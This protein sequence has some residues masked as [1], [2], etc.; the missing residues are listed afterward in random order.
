MGDLMP[1]VAGWSTLISAGLAEPNRQPQQAAAAV[2][3]ISLVVLV[4]QDIRASATIAHAMLYQMPCG[5]QTRPSMD[6]ACIAQNPILLARDY[7][8]CHG[9]LTGVPT[10]H[11]FTD[12]QLFCYLTIGVTM[13]IAA[14]GYTLWAL[15]LV[16]AI[17]MFYVS[18][19]IARE[20]DNSDSLYANHRIPRV[21]IPRLN[22][23]RN[24]E[25]S[26]PKNGNISPDFLRKDD[27]VP[28][29]FESR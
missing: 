16:F 4:L 20:N 9:I 22:N 18:A 11:G 17:L 21:T 13:T 29:F 24:S 12:E 26:F 3:C 2:L 1:P 5:N 7:A 25:I 23:D 28:S 10:E 19:N 6:S 27:S 8:A 14:R 15:N